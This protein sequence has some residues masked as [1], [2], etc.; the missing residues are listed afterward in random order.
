MTWTFP[1][2][3]RTATDPCISH[4]CY[5]P[6][7][8]LPLHVPYFPKLPHLYI[9]STLLGAACPSPIW[10]ID[11][12]LLFDALDLSSG[13]CLEQMVRFSLVHSL[14]G[15]LGCERWVRLN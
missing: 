9:S 8:P 6:V 11:H 1:F 3:S 10:G 7:S 12:C 5:P 13:L 4:A 2:I 15:F 14:F